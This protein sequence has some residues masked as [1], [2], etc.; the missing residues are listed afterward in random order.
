MRELG[1]KNSAGLVQY[2]VKLGVVAF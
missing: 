2:A 1:I